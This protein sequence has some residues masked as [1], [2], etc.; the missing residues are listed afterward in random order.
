MQYRQNMKCSQLLL[1]WGEGGGAD[2]FV[3]K[4]SIQVS[5]TGHM[6]LTYGHT[7]ATL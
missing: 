1:G 7:R 4:S 2:C 3:F 5:Q 6:V